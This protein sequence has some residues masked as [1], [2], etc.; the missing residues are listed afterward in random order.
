MSIPTNGRIIFMRTA[1][2][3]NMGDTID[4]TEEKLNQLAEEI[5]HNAVGSGTDT[6]IQ[7]TKFYLFEFIT[8][9]VMVSFSALTT[10]ILLYIDYWVNS[11]AKNLNVNIIFF[12]VTPEK[13]L[14][15]GII[16]LL[17]IEIIGLIIMKAKT[18]IMLIKE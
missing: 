15:A 2:I 12:N 11:V 1:L 16:I 8:I 13:I 17:L 14:S 4:E 10:V 9:I 18:F 7:H 6:L 5:Y 3:E